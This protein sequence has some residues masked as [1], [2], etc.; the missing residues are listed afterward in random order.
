MITDKQLLFSDAQDLSQVAASY[1]S[2]N[3]ID[4]A[5]L[6][7]GNE[8]RNLGALGYRSGLALVIVVDEAFASGGA[9]TLNVQLFS[10]ATAAALTNLHW[11]S[12]AQT[13]Q[14]AGTSFWSVP[15]TAALP[16]GPTFVIPLPMFGVPAV[17]YLRWLT[18]NYVI[19]GATTTAGT[20][21]SH[22]CAGADVPRLFVN[23]YVP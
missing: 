6:Q 14:T 16:H 20:I 13:A 5:P 1:V 18:L 10:G 9:A 12:G 19:A 23:A 11:S 3:T 17:T 21:T 22:L 7:S 2:T 15:G 4:T 8:G